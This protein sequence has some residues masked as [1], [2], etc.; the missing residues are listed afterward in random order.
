LP[1]TGPEAELRRRAFWSGTLTFGLVSI[2]VALFSAQR[3]PLISLRQLAPDGTPLR[4]LYTCPEEDRALDRDEIVRGYE[5]EPGKYVLLTEEE[6][7]A[8]EPEKSRD[9][10]LRRFVR[11]ERIDPSYFD[12]AYFLAPAGQSA[13][14]YV[15]LAE[16]MERTGLAGLGTFVMRSKEY[17]VAI[18]AEK[19]ILRAETLRFAD[20]LRAPEDLG[21]PEPRTPSEEAVEKTVRAV[22]AATR[23]LLDTEVLK[24]RRAERLLRLVR[25]KLSS[26][27][28]VVHPEGEGYEEEEEGGV[29]DL[30]ELLKRSVEQ[31]AQPAEAP[32]KARGGG[33]PRAGRR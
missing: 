1:E 20:E 2:P 14:P 13:R 7:E 30:M 26:G 27:E 15:L 21:L 3:P 22:R 16:T 4:R 29:V 25:R 24:D 33:R 23:K 28:D 19:G 11:A 10:V 5:V 32:G 6:L 12:R 31:E 9:M 8:A 17:I 18:L